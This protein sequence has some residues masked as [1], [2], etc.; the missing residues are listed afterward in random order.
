MK[1]P[2]FF[3]EEHLSGSLTSIKLY[4][5]SKAFHLL[6]NPSPEQNRCFK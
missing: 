2:L 5:L 4:T 6:L 1:Q 3:I